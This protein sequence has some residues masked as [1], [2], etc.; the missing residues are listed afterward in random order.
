MSVAEHAGDLPVA[1]DLLPDNR[2]I[3]DSFAPPSSD[4]TEAMR[5]ELDG[6]KVLDGIDDDAARNDLTRIVTAGI[7]AGVRQHVGA[8]PG[9]TARVVVEL[10]GLGEEARVP[11]QLCRICAAVEGIEYFTVEL[12][13]G[14]HERAGL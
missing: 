12:S 7:L 3:R 14:L 9:D 6:A 5:T 11:L 10:D 4:L 13:D 1:V 2:E 8:V